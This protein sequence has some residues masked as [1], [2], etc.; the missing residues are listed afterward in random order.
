MFCWPR[1]G[2]RR[3]IC[4]VNS[5]TFWIQFWMAQV[6]LSLVAGNVRRYFPFPSKNLMYFRKKLCSLWIFQCMLIHRSET[7]QHIWIWLARHGG[8][9]GSGH[10]LLHHRGLRPTQT[11]AGNILLSAQIWNPTNLG[12]KGQLFFTWKFLLV[13]N[14]FKRTSVKPGLCQ[15]GWSDWFR[16]VVLLPLQL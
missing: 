4:F 3:F 5:I 8:C 7:C 15:N 9:S 2:G 16:I 1:C 6:A 14:G 11:A 12:A 13:T 10:R